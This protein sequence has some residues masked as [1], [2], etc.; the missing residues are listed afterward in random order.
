M[1]HTQYTLNDHPWGVDRGRKVG[2][3]SPMRV[4]LQSHWREEAGT[5]R[6]VDA[7]FK[8]F[9]EVEPVTRGTGRAGGAEGESRVLRAPWVPDPGMRTASQ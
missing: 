1:W 2:N 4:P 6:G 3:G 7:N 8:N 9:S 5:G